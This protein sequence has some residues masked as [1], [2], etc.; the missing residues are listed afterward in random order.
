MCIAAQVCRKSNDVVCRDSCSFLFGR[1]LDFFLHF[2]AI[3][4][5]L[6]QSHSHSKKKNCNRISFAK[7]PEM[8]DRNPVQRTR[9]DWLRRPR[10]HSIS[11]ECG[12]IGLFCPYLWNGTVALSFDCRCKCATRL[13]CLNLEYVLHQFT[14]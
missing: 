13:L 7:T 2:D 6:L 10:T 11:F 5:C 14:S 9:Y 4:I 8:I 3:L 1:L 12:A